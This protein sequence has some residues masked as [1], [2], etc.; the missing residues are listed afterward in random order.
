MD[1]K[2]KS[3]FKN[4]S[5]K[6]TTTLSR[7]G[8][9]IPKN[10]FTDKELE[11][12]KKELM[13]T[14]FMDGAPSVAQNIIKP[15]PIYFESV[16]NIYLPRYWGQKY[17][18]MPLNN[19]LKNDQSQQM[20]SNIK[21]KGA[22]RPYQ[23]TIVDVYLKAAKEIGGGIISIGCGRGKTVIGIC[24]AASLGLKTLVVVHKEFLAT[25]WEERIMT[26]LPNAQ[27]GRIQGKVI[28]VYKKDVVIAMVQ[29][30]SQKQY[31]DLTF[32]DFGLVIFD[33]C[34]HLSA[35]IFSRAL[36]KTGSRH[37]LGLS[38]T[39]FR[40]DNLTYVFKTFLGD[41]VYKEDANEDNTV[42]VKAIHYFNDDPDYCNELANRMGDLN[43]PQIINNIC[44]CTKRN[45][46]IIDELK[47]LIMEGRKILLLSDRREHLCYIKEEISNNIPE[48]T[49]G[50]Y[51][52]A[53]KQDDLKVSEGCDIIL[54]T[55]SMVS[56]G[57]DCPS[58]DTIILGSPKSDVV[59]SVGRILRKKPE[60][61]D[62]QHIVLDIIDCFANFGRSWKTR[63]K[64]YKKQAFQIEQY[65][66]DDNSI[67]TLI[68][69][70][71]PPP[72]KHKTMKEEIEEIDFID[73]KEDLDQV[74]FTEE[75]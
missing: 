48:A 51:V 26:F 8:Y 3:V 64:F 7:H 13:A 46:V 56:E 5:K 60:D 29:S 54:G 43:R 40:K 68:K 71:A 28:D 22:L 9:R 37:T 12:L 61:R 35:E 24:I 27:V 30:L 52:G 50:L 47:E 17:F 57:F 20:N 21:F 34:H 74:D 45:K 33:E 66:Y 55:Y 1:K 44:S 39:P 69:E 15:F 14:P 53:M 2:P 70:G 19:R 16:E 72:R 18:G 59:Q 38:A 49:S 41:I 65:T 73:F 6:Y 58:L 11:N 25:Q 36:I 32:Q 4:A 75:K 67:R 31:S 23:Q 62:R 63:S 42:L 10:E